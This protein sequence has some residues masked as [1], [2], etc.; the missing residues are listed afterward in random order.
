MLD[1]KASC[2]PGGH[3]D[4]LRGGPR[5][6]CKVLKSFPTNRPQGRIVTEQDEP[7]NHPEAPEDE[8]LLRAR[9]R[10][11]GKK[12][13]SRGLIVGEVDEPLDEPAEGDLL[14]S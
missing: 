5:E 12:L 3:G 9:H 6:T 8:E 14:G 1:V 13:R 2:R 7:E 4:R 10:R 11:L